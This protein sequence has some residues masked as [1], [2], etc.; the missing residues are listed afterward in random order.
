M[1]HR[2]KG[3]RTPTPSHTHP[4]RQTDTPPRTRT[5]AHTHTHAH[6]H[7]RT[8]THTHFFCSFFFSLRAALEALQRIRI[9]PRAAALR[10]KE[11]SSLLVPFGR[12]AT[13]LFGPIA[14]KTKL[15]V[16]HFLNK[17]QRGPKH[18]RD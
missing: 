16:R 8:H 9:R 15:V 17:N 6:T 5:P 1:K 18:P 11:I 4:D 7:T 13:F 3:N 12:R 14:S 2:R 10:E